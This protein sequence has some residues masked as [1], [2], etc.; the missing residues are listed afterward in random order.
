[1]LL[2]GLHEQIAPYRR[3]RRLRPSVSEQKLTR[4]AGINSRKPALQGLHLTI[5]LVH[6]L[7]SLGQQGLNVTDRLLMPIPLTLDGTL[8]PAVVTLESL[9]QLAQLFDFT[10]S[11]LEFSAKLGVLGSGSP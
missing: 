8:M 6:S 10:R 11:D 9:N 7:P 3:I 1:V 5:A 4:G 2:E